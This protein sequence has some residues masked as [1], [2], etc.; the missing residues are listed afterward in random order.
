MQTRLGQLFKQREEIKLQH[1]ADMISKAAKGLEEALQQTD[2]ATG[3]LDAFAKSVD[4]AAQKSEEME[5]AKIEA[6]KKIENILKKEIPHLINSFN[7]S[8]ST[9]LNELFNTSDQ[10][11]VDLIVKY[12]PDL[13][14]IIK[15]NNQFTF[16][17]RT[18]SALPALA[19]LSRN[20]NF[21]INELIFETNIP[22]PEEGNGLLGSI[23]STFYSTK[24]A[25]ASNLEKLLAQI[26]IVNLSGFTINEKS[27]EALLIA[28]KSIND[29]L[30]VETIKFTDIVIHDTRIFEA[31]IG[32]RTTTIH[33]ER[34][35]LSQPASNY[36][37][38]LIKDN[39]NSKIIINKINVAELY[40]QFITLFNQLHDLNRVQTA[41]ISEVKEKFAK[42]NDIF[43]EIISME[44]RTLLD[45]LDFKI[46]STPLEHLCFGALARENNIEMRKILAFN[47]VR[48]QHVLHIEYEN[49]SLGEKFYTFLKFKKLMVFLEGSIDRPGNNLYTLKNII[50]E[51]QSNCIDDESKNILRNYQQKLFDKF[52][53]ID[54]S[55]AIAIGIKYKLEL[56]PA[57]Q[58]FANKLSDDMKSTDR[59]LAVSLRNTGNL[60]NEIKNNTALE[61]AK[62]LCF[63]NILLGARKAQSKNEIMIACELL[64]G[65]QPPHAEFAR[66]VNDLLVELAKKRIAILLKDHPQIS[67]LPIL[68][69]N[70]HAAVD[71]EAIQSELKHYITEF[72]LF[73]KLFMK[74]LIEDIKS[75]QT[76]ISLLVATV[77]NNKKIRPASLPPLTVEDNLHLAS[78]PTESEVSNNNNN[79]PLPSAPVMDDNDL[80]EL[81]HEVRI[82]DSEIPNSQQ[83]NNNLPANNSLLRDQS[84]FAPQID[85]NAMSKEEIDNLFPKTPQQPKVAMHS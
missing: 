51:A 61:T 12:R 50:D 48:K 9:D 44:Q 52:C 69:K 8:N 30:A 73:N 41:Q 66:Q 77:E 33:F 34:T 68:I 63:T 72:S 78:A 3:F 36:L 19:Q 35:K 6:E 54:P 16:N 1:N 13:K 57:Y 4:I 67:T 56:T 59:F 84:L 75:I 28:K 37:I 40:H 2:Q 20:R 23:L 83:T 32:Y 81:S 26:K 24:D 42:L 85:L 7:I 76:D 22:T 43:P 39:K 65:L 55:T 31:L 49:L 62:N 5:L 14:P 27:I 18:I 10:K 71:L 21:P 38:N 25:N 60:L 46:L 29:P 17:N 45:T 70:T 15:H 80:S 47:L 53:T 58:A 64:K 82:S 79:N 11:E 74:N